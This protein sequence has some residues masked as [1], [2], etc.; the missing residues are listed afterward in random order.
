MKKEKKEKKEKKDK[1]KEDKKEAS[2]GS[3]VWA[4]PHARRARFR[5]SPGDCFEGVVP[6]SRA[7]PFGWQ[8]KPARAVSK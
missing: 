7:W 3:G 4:S 2:G 5:S 1:K 6:F 8:L